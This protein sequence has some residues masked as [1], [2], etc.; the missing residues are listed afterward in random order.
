MSEQE[1]FYGEEDLQEVL[2]QL[3][4]VD[5]V[6][7]ACVLQPGGATVKTDGIKSVDPA[8]F[9]RY[10][11]ETN[12]RDHLEINGETYVYLNVKETDGSDSNKVWCY[13]SKNPLTM[14]SVQDSKLGLAVMYHELG[15]FV[16]AICPQTALT[17]IVDDMYV[18]CVKEMAE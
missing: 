5:S 11:N 10:I 7:E 15:F 14:G 13:M 6:L 4:E 3:R 18:K 1:E 12:L 8:Q 9:L 16:V 17:L 2:N